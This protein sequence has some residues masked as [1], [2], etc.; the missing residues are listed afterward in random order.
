[1][2]SVMQPVLQSR[3]LLAHCSIPQH[4]VT[5]RTRASTVDN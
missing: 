5:G 3:V 4:S 1:M 2:N